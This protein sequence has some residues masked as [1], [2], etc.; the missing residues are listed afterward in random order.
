MA[1]FPYFKTVLVKENKGL[2]DTVISEE[3]LI[4]S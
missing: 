1:I 2:L 4:F 3:Q